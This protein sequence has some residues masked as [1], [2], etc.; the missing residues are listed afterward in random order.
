MRM[1]I[2]ITIIA[3]IKV[4]TSLATVMRICDNDNITECKEKSTT[5]NKHTTVSLG[6]TAKPSD[7]KGDKH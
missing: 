3:V 2:I 4:I 7:M 1:A 6:F 5:K